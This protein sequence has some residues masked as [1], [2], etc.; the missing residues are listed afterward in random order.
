MAV[1]STALSVSSLAM[2]KSSHACRAV[3]TDTLCSLAFWS[4]LDKSE[5]NSSVLSTVL[6]AAVPRP[7]MPAVTG[8]SLLLTLPSLS[9]T[10][11]AALEI[12]SS[13]LLLLLA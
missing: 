1:A 13:A 4:N 3:S 8:A 2:A 9:D 12:F 7:N 10:F 5:R 6:S 11:P